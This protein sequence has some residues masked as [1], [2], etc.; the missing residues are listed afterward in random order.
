MTA[1]SKR[2][3]N[4]LLGISQQ[5]DIRKIPGQVNK[6]T[7]AYPEYAIGLLKRAG[8]AFVSDLLN[9]G[10]SGRWFNIFLNETE[11]Y[12][13]QYHDN[14]FKIWLLEGGLP[15]RVDMKTV[16][17]QNSACNQTNYQ[18]DLTTYLG[19]KA[20]SDGALTVLRTKQKELKAAVDGSVTTSK[21]LLEF[22]YTY[23]TT[24]GTISEDLKSGAIVDK[25]DVWIYKD[26]GTVLGSTTSTLPTGYLLGD[27]FTDEYP[28]LASEGYKIYE[29]KKTVAATYTAAQVTAAQTAEASALSDYNTKKALTDTAESDLLSE[30]SSCNVPSIPTGDYLQGATDADLEFLTV[31]DYTLV[32]NKSK[33]VALKSDTSADSFAGKR[34]FVRVNNAFYNSNYSIAVAGGGLSAGTKTATVQT[35]AEVNTDGSQRLEV[36][37]ICDDLITAFNSSG[38][39]APD[40]DSVSGNTIVRIGSGLL[41]SSNTTFSIGVSGGITGDSMTVFQDTVES[42]AVLPQQCTD[43]YIVKIVNSS[44]LT[45]DD[46]YVKFNSSAGEGTN[47][48]GVWIETLAPNQQF[49]IDP[50]TMPHKIEREVDGSFTFSE[51]SWNDRL[52]GDKETSSPDPAFIGKQISNMVFYRN[53]LAFISGDSVDMS[54]TGDV[55]NFFATSAIQAV[56]DDPIKISASTTRAASLRYAQAVQAGLVLFGEKQQ[57]LLST[58]GD[59]LSPKTAKINSISNYECD[60]TLASVE[61]GSST[62]FASKTPLYTRLFEFTTFTATESPEYAELTVAIPELI[63]STVDKIVASSTQSLIAVGSSGQKE[64]FFYRFISQGDSTVSTWFTWELSGTLLHHFFDGSA[65][66]AVTAFGTKVHINKFNLSQANEQGSLTLYSGEKTDVCLDNWFTNPKVTYDSSTNLSTFGLPY[67]NP[68]G[69]KL[70]LINTGDGTVSYPTL[71]D[72]DTSFTVS[73][74]LRGNDVVLGYIYEMDIGLPKF[75]MTDSSQGAVL[76]DFTADLILHRVKVSLGMSGPVK[77]KINIT[78]IPEYTKTVSVTQ[79]NVYDLDNINLSASSTHEVPIYQR[80]ENLTMNIIADTPYP[81]SLLAVVWEGRVGNKFY[82]RS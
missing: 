21:N 40:W 70:A 38:G 42:Q 20:V 16:H 69:M 10:T 46:M 9:A 54:R 1:V 65:Y 48:P 17:G 27:E 22:T 79:P 56:D 24:A 12:I 61:L 35:P 29:L 23:N 57:F 45:T 76:S 3:P 51:I 67:A 32:L 66:Y 5:P 39:S 75:Y 8:G 2:I 19:A 11:K 44:D 64:I 13:A 34:A 59:I 30:I 43:G 52:V 82:K 7:N 36:S 81:C 31:G 25:D 15:R 4:L 71:S 80:N 74:D 41:I 62:I 55:F 63:P 53:R 26:N 33:T 77:Y 6:L 49:K 72:G 58:D 78:G 18:S 14:R 37:D 47:G 50:K 60:K 28:M 68:A 73:N